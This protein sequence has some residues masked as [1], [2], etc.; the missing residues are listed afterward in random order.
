MTDTLTPAQQLAHLIGEA[1]A[2]AAI[3]AGWDA[4][5]HT[6]TTDPTPSP[7]LDNY[8][9][10]ILVAAAPAIRTQGRRTPHLDAV[11]A[12]RDQLAALLPAGTDTVEQWGVRLYQDGQLADESDPPVS[13]ERAQARVDWHTRKRAENPG[14]RGTAELVHR[15][16]H[17]TPWRLV[18]DGS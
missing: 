7:F 12:E 3:N 11:K 2:R 18:E 6:E 5:R 15:H 14:W 8:V 16:Q 1:A 13:R 17:T 4:I 10:Q 9:A